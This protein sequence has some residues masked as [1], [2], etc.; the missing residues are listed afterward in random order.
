MTPRIRSKHSEDL[1]ARRSEYGPYT[2]CLPVGRE[3][4]DCQGSRSLWNGARNDLSLGDRG[5]PGNWMLV[6]NT[7]VGANCYLLNL[8]VK[9]LQQC[10]HIHFWSACRRGK[11][12]ITCS[13]E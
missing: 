3:R 1:H 10:T 13:G 11:R 6:P 12:A 9:W 2:S 5:L 8:E 7:M 4:L